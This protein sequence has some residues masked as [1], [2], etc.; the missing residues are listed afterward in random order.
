M[1]EE[2]QE[3]IV[4][5]ERG[6]NLHLR[7]IGLRAEYYERLS[8]SDYAGPAMSNTK[9]GSGN[10]TERK[11]L[12]LAEAERELISVQNELDRVEME[13]REAV[14]QVENPLYQTYLRMRFLS[15]RTN[16]QIAKEINYSP[17]HIRGKIHRNAI[18]ALKI[19]TK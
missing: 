10:G 19:N 16:E 14:G 12:S 18:D 8:R 13:I 9:G 4:W 17:E 15:Y 3:K 2:R 5:L 7:L 1:K 6:K 11:F